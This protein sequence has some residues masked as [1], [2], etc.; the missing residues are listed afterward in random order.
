MSP[1]AAWRLESLGFERVFDYEAGKTDWTG[2]GLPTEGEGAERPRPGMIAIPV[3]TC[4][5]GEPVREV[6]KRVE[7][8]D[9]TMCIVVTDDD[10]VLGRVTLGR[11]RSNPDAV[12]D[13]VM[14]PGPTTVRYDE[15]I[16][17]LTVRMQDKEVGSI[18]VTTPAGKLIGVMYRNVAEELLGDAL[19]EYRAH[20]E[21]HDH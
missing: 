5:L 7:D 3:A 1:R 16:V 2:S 8:A 19:D 20:Q 14:T 6:E 11:L 10:V 13:D 18:L 21:H 12:V 4:R 9:D 15:E 17:G